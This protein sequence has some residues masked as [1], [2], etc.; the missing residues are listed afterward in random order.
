MTSTWDTSLETGNELIDR[1]HREIGVLVDQLTGAQIESHQ[2]VLRVLDKVIEFTL[3][4]FVA[5][6][7]LMARVNY[8]V[9]LTREMTEQHD[10]FKSYMRLR[11]LEFRKAEPTPIAPLQAFLGDW[12]RSHESGLDRKLAEWI[13][14]QAGEGPRPTRVDLVA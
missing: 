1:Q 5:E 3:E 14:R 7:M 9:G 12:L 4:H 6:E 8:P 10:S 2:E 13:R 11:V